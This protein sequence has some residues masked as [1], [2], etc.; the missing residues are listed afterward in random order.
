M[1]DY[2]ASEF[3]FIIPKEKY[4]MVKDAIG[5]SK[6]SIFLKCAGNKFVRALADADN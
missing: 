4:E 3:E 5:K 6:S 2:K 1:E